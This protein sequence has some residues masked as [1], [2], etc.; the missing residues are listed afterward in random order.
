[1]SIEL[2]ALGEVWLTCKEYIAPKDRQAAADHVLAIVAD[3]N[4]VERELKAF[5][6]TDS[7]LKRA[8]KEYLGEDEEPSAYDD[9]DGD[10]DY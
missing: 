8:L 6:G 10:D 1:M 5:G 4:I 3:H 7:Y 9:D 2:D